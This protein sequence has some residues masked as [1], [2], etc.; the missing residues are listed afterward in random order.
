MKVLGICGSPRVGNTEYYIKVVLEELK[1]KGFEA[2]YIRLRNKSI[3]QCEGCYGCIENKKC[4]VEDD[5]Q[6]IFNKMLEAD[7]FIVGSPV[8]NGSITPRLKALLDRAGFSARW[9]KNDLETSG[10]KYDWGQM[11]FSRKIFAPITVARKT[12]QTFAFAQLAL[13]ATVND[14]IITGSNYWTVGSAGT[15]GSVNANEDTEGISIMQ[16]LAGNID[17]VIKKLKS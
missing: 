12:G 7:G 13:W 4:V 1:E 10:G 16:H 11:P 14:F 5:F 6:E 15:S 2:E 17:Y 8:Y 3:S 9:M